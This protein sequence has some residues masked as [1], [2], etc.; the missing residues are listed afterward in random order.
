PLEWFGSKRFVL[1]IVALSIIIGGMVLAQGPL[2]HS[3][4]SSPPPCHIF[5]SSSS[6]ECRDPIQT[7][8]NSTSS[9]DFNLYAGNKTINT[10]DACFDFLPASASCLKLQASHSNA[11]LIALSKTTIG[12]LSV[13]SKYLLGFSQSFGISNRLS[14]HSRWRYYLTTKGTIPRHDL[15]SSQDYNP[16]DDPSVLLHDVYFCDSN[17]SSANIAV[18]DRVHF[19]R[20][21]GKGDTISSEAPSS[22]NAGPSFICD[23]QTIPTG[24]VTCPNG[25]FTAC[26][27]S[28]L[29]LN[30]TGVVNGNSC[31][32]TNSNGIGPAAGCSWAENSPY[33]T[34]DSTRWTSSQT[35]PWFQLQAS[36]YYIGFYASSGAGSIGFGFDNGSHSTSPAFSGMKVFLYTPST[37]NPAI[38][39]GGF[40]GPVIKALIN[41][42]IYILNA[43]LGFIAFIAPAI[44]TAI[45][46]L[47]TLIQNIL[48]FIGNALGFGNVGTQLFTFLNQVITF[49]TSFLPNALTNFPTFM[50]RFF[51]YL[52]IVFPILPSAFATALTV[53]TFAVNGISQALTI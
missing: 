5:P 4:E 44:Q 50:S 17:C 9:N 13:A 48:N 18:E 10:I 26:V 25:S 37:S 34:V 15:G 6:S 12:D 53:L 46:F 35:L 19:L 1:G 20:T 27:S 2:F 28:A 42:G 3:F 32:I 38:D 8:W 45:T 21:I 41:L 43:I 49:F 40:F 7:I 33:A 47:E 52:N 16:A 39:T 51:D 29:Y 30:F 36:Q 14:L 23:S 22:C 24:F 31:T 11:T